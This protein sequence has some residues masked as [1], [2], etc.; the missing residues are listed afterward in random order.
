MSDHQKMKSELIERLEAIKALVPEI[1]M[2]NCEGPIDDAIAELERQDKENADLRFLLNDHRTV[3]KQYQD[4]IERQ[5]KENA[6]L[7]EQNE[8]WVKSFVEFRAR[9]EERDDQIHKLQFRLSHQKETTQK[10]A[11]EKCRVFLQRAEQAESALLAV[12]RVGAIEYDFF[13]G[14]IAEECPDAAELIVR[15]QENSDE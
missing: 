7:R 15:L 9:L 11:D 3:K 12:M 10:L 1:G 4:E 2:A 8:E 14:L 13:A 5:D 6:A